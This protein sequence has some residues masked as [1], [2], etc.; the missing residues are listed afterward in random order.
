MLTSEEVR[1]IARLARVG[2]TDEEV[3]RFRAQL[4]SI[5]EHFE[6]LRQVNTEGVQPTGHAVPLHNV[7]REDA[8]APSYPREEI[9][10]NAPLREDDA[11][12]VQAVLEF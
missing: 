11:F 12:R 2:V 7:M 4:S 3:E 1:H 10:A 8:P 9:L 6:T 5:L